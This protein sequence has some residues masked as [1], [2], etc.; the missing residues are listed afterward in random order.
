MRKSE[1][2]I[3][4]LNKRINATL[5]ESAMAG[6]AAGVIA[7]AMRTSGIMELTAFVFDEDKKLAYVV[8][9]KNDSVDTLDAYKFFSDKEQIRS[10]L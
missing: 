3:P 9:G 10:I 5:D 8:V 4:V 2:Y 7:G 1:I 6:Y